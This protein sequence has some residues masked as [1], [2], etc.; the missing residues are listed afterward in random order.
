MAL[1]LFGYIDRICQQWRKD[2]PDAERVPAVLP[3]V[4]HHGRAGWTAATSLGELY[5][6][7][8]ETRRSSRFVSSTYV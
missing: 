1:R 8:E 6:L 5:D 2:H 4:V 7:D 3:V